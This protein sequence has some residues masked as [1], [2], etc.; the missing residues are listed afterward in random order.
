VI[1][2]VRSV[3]GTDVTVELYTGEGGSG[4]SLTVPA[5]LHA[6][7]ADG[8]R[9]LVIF[10]TAEVASAVVV[11]RVGDVDD[12]FNG[13]NVLAR[14]LDVDGTGSGLDAD[15]VDGQHEAA[16]LRADGSRPLSA[17]W[18]VGASRRILTETAR[19]RS[20]AGL[21][22]EDASGAVGLFVADGGNVGVGVRA[23]QGRLHGH[24]GTG[25]FLHVSKTG[26]G[27][28]AVVLIA[29]GAG[30]VTAALRGEALVRNGTSSVYSAFTLTLGGTTTQNV[31]LGSDTY[32]FRLNADGSFDVRRTAGSNTGTAVVRAMWV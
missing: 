3:V 1:G 21:A 11:G 19:A 13:A 26:I 9:V 32:Q 30:D 23:P 2:L 10:Q 6:D 5:L 27:T 12:R 8:D 4:F 16:L 14:L 20:S 24:D 28:T 17:D 25:G 7:Y 22:L 31:T 18:D 29:N 15:K